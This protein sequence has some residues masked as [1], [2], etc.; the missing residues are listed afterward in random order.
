[1]MQMNKNGVLIQA[2]GPVIDVR[3]PSDSIPKLLTALKV[4]FD[5]HELVLEVVEHIG[6]DKVRCI[7]LG[8]TSGIKRGLEVINTDKTIEVK[9]LFI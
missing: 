5:N 6:D 2:I 8:S 9:N 3:F 4:N 1:M 7:A